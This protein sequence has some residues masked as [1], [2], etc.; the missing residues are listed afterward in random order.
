[1]ADR[2]EVRVEFDGNRYFDR[3]SYQLHD[4]EITQFD[5]SGRQPEVGRDEI[6]VYF[7]PVRTGLLDLAC[8]FD[9]SV[10]R[11][12]IQA[13][14]DRDIDALLSLTNNFKVLASTYRKLL[15]V[16]KKVR[17]LGKCGCGRP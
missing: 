11:D 15:K 16:R 4:I 3:A 8:V 13:G 12:S 17:C 5:V 10:R 14:D 7:E 6:Y 1:M 2:R 9:P